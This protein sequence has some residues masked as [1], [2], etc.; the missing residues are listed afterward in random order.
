EKELSELVVSSNHVFRVFAA[1]DANVQRTLQLLPGALSKTQSG[2]GKLATAA[3]VLGPTLAALHPFATD[4][5]PAQRAGQQFTKA[6]TPIIATQIRPFARE[7]AP[8]IAK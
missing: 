3:H 7:A 6:T 8:A 1:Q 4:L 5:A 2:L